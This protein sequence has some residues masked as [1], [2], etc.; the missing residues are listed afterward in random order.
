MRLLSWN[1]RGAG[2]APTVRALKALVRYEGPDVL[3]VAETKVKSPKMDMLKRG[4]GFSFCFCVDSVGKSGG[5][6]LFWKMC[7]ELEVVYSDNNLIAALV[8]S[9]PP[10]NAW[11]LLVVY[12]PPYVAN[13]NHFWSLLENMV[14]SFSGQWLIIGDLN[15]MATRSE[16]KGGSSRG[17]ISSRSFQNFV[18]NTGALD[19]GFIGPKF[20]WSNQRVG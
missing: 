10:E 2:R 14:N 6:A 9:D 20:T 19:L 8:Y 17:I 4:M 1:C 11:L 7:I 5:L 15:S 3:F 18:S 13:R 16:K 12:G